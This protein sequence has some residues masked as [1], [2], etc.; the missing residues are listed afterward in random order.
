M[1]IANN[2]IRLREIQSA[3]IND[4][5]VFAN[6]NSVSISTIDRVLKR[7]QM[8]MKQLY[9]VPFERNSERV[10][11]LRY[12]YVQRMM[13]L[14]VHET[15]H[16]LVFVDEAGFNLSKGRRRGRNL[17]GHRA[18]TDTPGQRGANITMCAAISENGVSTHIPHIGPYNTQLLLAFLN[19]LYRDLIPEQERGLRS[20]SSWQAAGN[21]SSFDMKW[22]HTGAAR[23]KF[24]QNRHLIILLT[25]G[26]CRH[27]TYMKDKGWGD[28]W[29]VVLLEGV[30]WLT[31]T[32]LWTCEMT[33][34]GER[35][36]VSV[37]KSHA[38]QWLLT[39][40]EWMEF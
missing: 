32:R 34:Q 8:T 22:A 35:P 28:C 3:I 12:Q 10:K 7:H 21:L 18:T 11:E 37:N 39:D 24:N 29:L 25:F 23:C 5:N 26:A 9:K 15:T 17:I 36:S 20:T 16:I 40:R 4:N 1:V 30:K 31:G 13:E 19:T 2:S 38:N 27:T 14:E 33:V 6:I